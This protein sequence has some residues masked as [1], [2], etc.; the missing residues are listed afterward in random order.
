MRVDERL[1]RLGAAVRMFRPAF[2]ESAI[3][4][5]HAAPYAACRALDVILVHKQFV[6]RH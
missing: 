3:A 6:I 1:T 5:Q 2:R 4:G